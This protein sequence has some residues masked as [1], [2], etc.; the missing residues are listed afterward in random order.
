MKWIIAIAVY[1]TI[2]ELVRRFC[3]M[4][5]EADQTMHKSL[6]QSDNDKKFH[7]ICKHSAQR[8][9]QEQIEND[10]AVHPEGDAL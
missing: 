2:V 7:D 10:G 1:I 6:Q 9:A 8:R 4:G 3:K 5:A